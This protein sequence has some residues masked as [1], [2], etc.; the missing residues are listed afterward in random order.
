MKIQGWC[1]RCKK[2]RTVRVDRFHP[3]LTVQRGIC[4]VCE[5]EQDRE[6]DERIKRQTKE[7]R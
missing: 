6:R 4:S 3:R 5:A 2:L 1:E 7:K